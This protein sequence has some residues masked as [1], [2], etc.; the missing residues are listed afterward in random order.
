VRIFPL[1]ELGSKPSRHL[2]YVTD[3]LSAMGYSVTID[4][5]SYEFQRGGNK[6]MKIVSVEP[7]SA[8]DSQ[9]R[10]TLDRRGE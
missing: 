1:L 10:A 4:R 9:G 7:G 6:M 5:V 2:Q 8:V 3:S